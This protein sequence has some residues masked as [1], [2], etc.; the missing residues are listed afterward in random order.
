[1]ILIIDNYDSFTHNLARYFQELGQ[2]VEVVRNDVVSFDK[3]K[4]YKLKA[5]VVSPGP[6]SPEESAISLQAVE[7]FAD[8]IPI[9]GVCLGHQAIGQVFGGQVVRATKIMHGK[10]SQVYHDGTGVFEGLE[11]PLQ[12]VRYHSLVL[13]ANVIPESF[14]VTAWAYDNSDSVAPFEGDKVVMAIEHKSLPI[15]GVQFHPE[16]VLSHHGHRVLRNFCTLA[17][18]GFVDQSLENLPQ[19]MDSSAEAM[20]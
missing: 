20:N 6:C 18:L 17:G 2:V 12:V 14:K 15:F 11:S 13:A 10:A 5:L 16:S 8:K 3:L 7:Y 9:L 1:M 19:N 4:N